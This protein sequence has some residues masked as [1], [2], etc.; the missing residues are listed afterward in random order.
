MSQINY[1][2]LAG[3]AP[4]YIPP[5]QTLNYEINCNGAGVFTDTLKIDTSGG[6][7][8]TTFATAAPGLYA[9][10]VL[11]PS[12]TPVIGLMVSSPVRFGSLSPL[13]AN[14]RDNG[15]GTFALTVQ[16]P[17]TGAYLDNWLYLQ[18]T[19]YVKTT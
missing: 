2:K 19:I 4:P 12:G 11:I 3:A 13:I 1:E 17:V 15:S 6:T 16:D 9:G 14:I 7:I 18:L 10:T 5:Y 8:G